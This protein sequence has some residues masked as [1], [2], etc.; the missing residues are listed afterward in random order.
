MRNLSSPQTQLGALRLLAGRS[1]PR[2]S[3]PSPSPGRAVPATSTPL[4][5]ARRGRGPF[6]QESISEGAATLDAAIANC[7][8]SGRSW[9]TRGLFRELRPGAATCAGPRRTSPTRSSPAPRRCRARAFNQQVADAAPD[10]RSVRRGPA[11]AARHHALT[12]PLA[13]SLNPT[14]AYLAPAQTVCNYVTLW[15]RN[16]S[17]CSADGDGNGTWQRFIIIATPQGPNNE[18]GPSWRPANGPRR[19]LPAR[20]PL[21]EH[22][23]A[24][25]GPRECEAANEAYLVGKRS[26]GNVP[27]NQGTSTEKTTRS[28]RWPSDAGYA[29]GCAARTALAPARSRSARIV[30]LIAASSTFLGFTKDIPFTHGFRARP[31][32]RR[33][34]RSGRTRR[35]ASPASPSAR[36][37]ASRASPG[38]TT[39]SSRWRSTRPACR[40]TRT[41]R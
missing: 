16:V 24:R 36:S 17:S 12:S 13:K 4:L 34:C 26:I 8:S 9:P 19:Q 18:G 3:R 39:R 30:L 6:I 10:A 7:R 22:R 25:P 40:S 41:P 1:S 35:C 29:T 2:A 27:G 15:F 20:Q 23:L 28:Q 21:P 5:G 11:G 31:S 32:S 38:R 37:R 14:L 33:P